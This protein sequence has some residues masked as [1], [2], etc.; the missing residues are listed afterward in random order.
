MLHWLPH[1][2]PRS[3]KCFNGYFSGT[4]DRPNAS[5]ATTW[6]H[7]VAQMFHW[8]SLETRFRPNVSLA[9]TRDS[10]SPKCLLA[11]TWDPRPPT[12]LA[13]Y[14]HGLPFGDGTLKCFTGDTSATLE[15]S[16]VSLATLPR[17]KGS[18]MFR[19]LRPRDSRAL[20]CSLATL[21][22]PWGAQMFRWLHFRDP[23]ALKS[24]TGYNPATLGRSNVSLAIL[25]RPWGAQWL[26]WLHRSTT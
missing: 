21:S 13:G 1:G 2:D 9:I 23:G 4:R 6:G 17:P 20:K 24:F 14:H 3:A 15:R 18:Q 7:R 8:L 12:C 22:R 16:N 11:T 10:N 19:W 5:L 25:S 26:Q